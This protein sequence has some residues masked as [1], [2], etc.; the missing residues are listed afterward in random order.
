MK[1]YN[2]RLQV[3]SS[4]L[5]ST[6]KIVMMAILLKVDWK[7][8]EGPVT[9]NQIVNMTN[10]KKRTVQRSIKK[11]VTHKWITRTSKH[12]QRELNTIGHTRVLVDQIKGMTLMTPIQ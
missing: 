10:L 11:L 12:I 6:E 8:F 7:S 9:I 3:L 4:N 2:V 1:E 5:T